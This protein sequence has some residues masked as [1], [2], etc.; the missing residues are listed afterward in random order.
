MLKRIV[1]F[2]IAVSIL[3]ASPSWAGANNWKY[4]GKASTGEG[5]TLNLDSVIVARRSLG[6][7]QPP[8]Y[9]FRYKIGRD[10]V[11]AFT[12]CEGKY[13][14]ST[15]GNTFK[16]LV[17]PNS[18]ATRNMLDL[19]CS[20]R[21]KAINIL[22]PPSNVRIGPNDRILCTLSRQTTITTYGQYNY[23]SGDDWFYTDI[24]GK[25]GLIHSSQIR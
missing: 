11:F 25:L 15:D 12:N 1:M 9:F 13:S 19:V 23:G 7:V 14:T 6:R 8:S 20:Y 2:S 3:I 24:C 5:V 16:N 17:K 10:H 21:I 22:S 4:Q 18:T